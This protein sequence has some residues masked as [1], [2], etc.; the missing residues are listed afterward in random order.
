MNPG[1]GRR[2]PRYAPIQMGRSAEA[3][4]EASLSVVVG[5]FLGFFL[6]RW[7][8]TGPVFTIALLVLG[9]VAGFRRL[10]RLAAAANAAKSE[11]PRG[12]G[13]VPPS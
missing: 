10:M 3:A 9:M 11:P 1:P 2:R 12:D 13:D 6:D 5:A 4:W 7:L 8:G